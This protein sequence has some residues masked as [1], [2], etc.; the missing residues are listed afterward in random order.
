MRL[1]ANNPFCLPVTS[2]FV[3]TANAGR[4]IKARKEEKSMK[5]QC[6]VCSCGGCVQCGTC[7]CHPSDEI[8]TH[9]G[10]VNPALTQ[11]DMANMAKPLPEGAQ[12][13][14]VP[15]YLGWSP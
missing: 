5:H 15:R 7:D 1:Q 4:G 2:H 8:E 10:D 9:P 11:D 14:R 3:G 13:L 6:S 12:I